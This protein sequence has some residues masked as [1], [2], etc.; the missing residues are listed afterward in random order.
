QPFETFWQTAL[1]DGVIAGSEWPTTTPAL[2]S[3]LFSQREMHPTAYESGKGYDLVIAPDPSV[4]DGRFA[5]NGWLQEWPQPITRLSWDNA[6]LMSPKTASALG[7]NQLAEEGAPVPT[8]SGGEHGRVV[9]DMVRLSHGRRT[10]EAAAFIVPGH[11]DG[12]LTLHLGYG[13]THA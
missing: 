13:R 5:N 2:V 12:V 3:E 10:L 8:T 11:T 9:A 6:V 7:I 1:H 4:Y